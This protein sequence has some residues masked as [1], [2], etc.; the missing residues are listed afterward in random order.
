MV[1]GD[2]VDIVRVGT[3]TSEK[4]FWAFTIGVLLSTTRIVKFEV[5][6]A[7]GEPLI[8]PLVSANPAGSEPEMI[9][10]VYGAVPFIAV[11]V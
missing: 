11:R 6:V 3:I 7:V 10:N 9:E 5:P 1:I 8:T 2:K 4:A